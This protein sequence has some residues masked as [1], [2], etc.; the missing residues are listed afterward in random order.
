MACARPLTTDADE[1]SAVDWASW[2]QQE[3]AAAEQAE[4]A[5]SGPAANPDHEDRPNQVEWYL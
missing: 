1:W 5:M 3:F 2:R 4:A